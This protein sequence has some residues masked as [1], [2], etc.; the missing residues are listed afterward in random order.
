MVSATSR[1]SPRRR[2]GICSS[3]IFSVPGERM[4][5]RISPGAMAFTRMPWAPNSCAISRVRAFSAALEQ[6]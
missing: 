1:A 6:A 4:L 3:T 5:V 2:I